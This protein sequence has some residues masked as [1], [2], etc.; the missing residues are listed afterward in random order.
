VKAWIIPE[1]IELDGEGRGDGDIALRRAESF[2]SFATSIE[3][4]D[5]L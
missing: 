4:L 1:A 3:L 2:Q 5:S